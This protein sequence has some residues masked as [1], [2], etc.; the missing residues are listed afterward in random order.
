MMAAA[1]KRIRAA[2]AGSL[3]LICML[4]SGCW[5]EVNLQN[6]SYITALGID[7]KEGQFTIYAQMLT[8]SAIAKTESPQ[9]KTAPV[10]IGKSQGDSVQMAYFNLSRASYTA[11]SLEQLKTIVVH[12]RALNHLGDVLDGL[13]RQRAARYT[14]VLF[15][16]NMPLEK[17]FTTDYFLNQSPLNSPLYEPELNES[18]YTFANVQTMQT[19]VQQVRDPGMTAMLPALDATESYWLQSKKKI[20]TQFISG[21]HVFKNL[22][23]Q[24]FAVEK[25]VLG[26][27]WLNPAFQKVFTKVELDG[28]MATI[29][30]N[31]SS[32][33]RRAKLSGED[34][35]FELNI[36]LKGHIVEMDGQM[37]KQQLTVLVEQKVK[38]EIEAAYR[39]GVQKKMDLLQLE[40]VLY[41]YHNSYWKAN[42]AAGKWRPRADALTVKVKMILTDSGK[43][44]MSSGN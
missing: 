30:I 19:F 26:I 17:L 40:H 36:E 34:A 15:G 13:N 35:R 31:G 38:E 43:F 3:A 23:Y 44:E 1:K 14:T 22:A 5:D 42:A 41:R 29:S 18:Q 7:Y 8:F 4:L 25:D 28:S 32:A 33:K 9:T 16:T 39:Y 27:R 11:L 37:S 12:E 6:M 21:V 2:A 24:G 10:W 20:S